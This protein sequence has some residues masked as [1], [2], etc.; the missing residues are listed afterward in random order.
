MQIFLNIPHQICPKTCKI[1][2]FSIFSLQNIKDI[3]VFRFFL[4]PLRAGNIMFKT[5]QTRS[6]VIIT[7]RL[8]PLA[9]GATIE[10]P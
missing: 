1:Y 4:L 10:V 7:S 3:C 2:P 8:E 9:L 6:D 5:R